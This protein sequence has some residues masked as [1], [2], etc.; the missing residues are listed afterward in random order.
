[1]T[2]EDN[3]MKTFGNRGGWAPYNNFDTF[4]K[5]KIEKLDGVTLPVWLTGDN[6][7]AVVY[8]GRLG[9]VLDP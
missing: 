1:M 7:L 3:K 2:D 9:A 4:A 6:K 5:A 8:G